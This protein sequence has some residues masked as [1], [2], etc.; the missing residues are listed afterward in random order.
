MI[1]CPHCEYKDGEELG[2]NGDW[3]TI[4][5]DK[6]DFWMSEH[7]MKRNVGADYYSNGDETTY[8]LACPNCFKTFIE[9]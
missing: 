5:G 2:D 9:D 8:L 6:G 3:V 7:P 4:D 1:T